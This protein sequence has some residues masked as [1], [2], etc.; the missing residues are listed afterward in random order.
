M[1]STTGKSWCSGIQI[2]S[3]FVNLPNLALTNL[4]FCSCHLNDFS[5]S[6]SRSSFG[7]SI[8]HGF[9]SVNTPATPSGSLG[10][11]GPLQTPPLCSPPVLRIHNPD[12]RGFFS[13]G[14]CSRS[15]CLLLRTVNIDSPLCGA[16]YY[17]FFI[18]VVLW[19]EKNI[20]ACG[21]FLPPDLVSLVWLF[22]SPSGDYSR[23]KIPFSRFC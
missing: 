15:L 7:S 17:F 13:V 16:N 21:L 20:K 8:P 19:D 14:S 22:G 18:F 3:V 5:A 9:L 2:T 10:T 1:N 6:S 23:G 11:L 4:C 12:P